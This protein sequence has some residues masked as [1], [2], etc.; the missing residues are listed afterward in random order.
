MEQVGVWIKELIEQNR[1]DKFYKS[2]AWKELSA[3]VLK[4][5]H[6]ECQHCKERG[7]HKRARSVHH[8]KHV[9]KY[10]SLALSRFYEVKGVRHKNLI[11]LCEECHNKEHKKG[12]FSASKKG[13]FYNEERW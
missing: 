12:F 5:N 3:A 11:P 2:K 1:L 7:I 9:R 4:E 13:K 10:P 8:V 6:Y